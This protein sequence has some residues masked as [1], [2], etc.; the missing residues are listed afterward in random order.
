M[1]ISA[2]VIVLWV[3]ASHA[4]AES[5]HARER[6]TVALHGE[7]TLVGLTAGIR[8]EALYRFGEADARSRVRVAIG[9]L[10]GPEQLFMPISIGYRAVF[11]TIRKVQPQF[12]AG[13]EVQHRFVSDFHTV[14]QFGFYLEGGVGFVIDRQLA[15]G[16][17]VA[18]DVMMYGGPGAG[19]GPRGFVSWRL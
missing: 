18:L 15:I 16:A 14:R 7:V 4:Q 10:D 2:A 13:L 1:R 17:I 3:S 8:P 9:L 12:G 6:F 11:R 19:I 5:W